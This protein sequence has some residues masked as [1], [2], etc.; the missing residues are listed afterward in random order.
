MIRVAVSELGLLRYLC[1]GALRH[2]VNLGDPLL[3]TESEPSPT[4]N[5][6]LSLLLRAHDQQ[7][8]SSDERQAPNYRRQRNSF[9]GVFSG[10]NGPD[11]KD[12]FLTGISDPLIGEGQR[13]QND[14]HDS[15]YRH[16]LQ[17][18][19]SVVSN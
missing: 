19:D 17:F 12:V 16:R 11:I 9:L 3:V 13:T 8:D 10:V 7:T 6:R 1:E 15:S 4:E 2:A 18:I 14:Q 5:S